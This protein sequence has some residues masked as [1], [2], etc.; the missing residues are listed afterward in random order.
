MT[1]G[2]AS[3]PAEPFV[4]R[5]LVA[6][7]GAKGL[8]AW[9]N[10]ESDEGAIVV[11]GNAEEGPTALFLRVLRRMA[12]LEYQGKCLQRALFVMA[13]RCEAYSL[14]ERR[15]VAL[16][17]L[18]HLSRGTGDGTLTLAVSDA[19]AEVREEL[20]ALL[21]ALLSEPAAR[22]V[23][24]FLHFGSPELDSSRVASDPYSAPMCLA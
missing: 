23:S 13:N 19:T 1:F 24:I 20:L 12:N 14:A 22:K 10:S 21:D 5:F 2:V 15:L 4:G 8:R 16:A 11:W 18:A 7:S 3:G 6:E 9:L 17:M